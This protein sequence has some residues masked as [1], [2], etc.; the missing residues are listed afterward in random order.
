MT[1]IIAN[2]YNLYKYITF[3]CNQPYIPNVMYFY[4]WHLGILCLFIIANI[5][6]VW[7]VFALVFC[8]TSNTSQA[9]MTWQM[10]RRS[11]EIILFLIARLK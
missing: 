10:H 8:N 7:L 6:K 3:F 1:L 2:F 11:N 5:S 4:T 9:S